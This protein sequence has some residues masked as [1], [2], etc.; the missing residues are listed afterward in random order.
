MVGRKHTRN[1][2]R[3]LA[4]RVH[5]EMDGTLGEDG[6]SAGTNVDL[7]EASAV[8]DQDTAAESCV[9]REVDLRSTGMGVRRVHAARAEVTDS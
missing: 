9:D 7:S 3:L 1:K 4:G 5:L 8:L 2:H 6:R